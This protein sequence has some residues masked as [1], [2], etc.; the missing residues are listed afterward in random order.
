MPGA[1][2]LVDRGECPFWTSRP[3]PSQRGAVALIVANN[4]PS[5]RMGG[6]LGA[7]T[8][9]KIPVVSVGKADGRS[10]GQ[11]PGPTTI[12]LDAEV[13]NVKTRNMI[14]QT[15][16]GSTQDVVMVGG[17]LDSVPQGPESTTTARGWPRCSRPPADGQLAAD[18]ERRAVRVLGGGGIGLVG[19]RS[20]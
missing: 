7:Q 8:D 20:T 1:V 18:K 16:T 4:A 17:H 12:K 5:E 19:S 6:T 9:V 10:C 15:K 14:A 3:L 2:V 11:Q 13:A